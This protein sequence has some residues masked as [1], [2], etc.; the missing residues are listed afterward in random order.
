MA[1]NA[2]KN[3]ARKWA[4]RGGRICQ[5]ERQSVNTDQTSVGSDN[6]TF[7]EHLL[8]DSGCYLRLRKKK[9]RPFFRAFFRDSLAENSVFWLSNRPS[10]RLILN[11]QVWS[12]RFHLVFCSNRDEAHLIPHPCGDTLSHGICSGRLI[13][14]GGRRYPKGK[15]SHF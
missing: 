13:S 5:E 3:Q 14:E 1:V 6:L 7:P 4:G 15:D 2:M 8:L 11:W 12:N 10:E 9:R